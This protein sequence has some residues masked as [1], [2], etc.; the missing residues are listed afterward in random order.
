MSWGL[1][2]KRPSD[3]FR[4]SL[5]YGYEESGED[6]DR[7]SSQLIGSYSSSSASLTPPQDQQEPGFKIDL[8]W[9]AGDDMD[10]VALRLQSQ[11]M[12]ALPLSQD[13][14]AIELKETEENEVRV[15]MYVEKR[16]EP[17]R[18][19]TVV[20]A[21]GTGQQSD[22]VGVLL[23]LLRSNLVPS[24]DVD[25]VAS[26]DHWKSITSLSLCGCGLTVRLS[27]T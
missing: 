26:D 19:V 15:E 6:L 18:A 27:L 25:P 2:W 20:K 13:T 23:R 24:V 12:V 4:L 10:Q 3:I 8:D 7:T 17:L 1:G 9:V 14:V 16:R 22:G 11:L 5:Y 21:T